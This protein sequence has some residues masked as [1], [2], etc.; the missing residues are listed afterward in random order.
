MCVCGVRV[1]SV[2]EVRVEDTTESVLARERSS[3]ECVCGVR[4]ECVCGVCVCGVRVECVC[5]VCVCEG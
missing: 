3:S 4:V 5:G 2:C 1:G